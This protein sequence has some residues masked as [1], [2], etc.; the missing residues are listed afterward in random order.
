MA[1]GG[2]W[3]VSVHFSFA[4]TFINRVIEKK[5]EGKGTLSKD[6]DGFMCFRNRAGSVRVHPTGLSP[7][8]ATAW[9]GTLNKSSEVNHG[10]MSAKAHLQSEEFRF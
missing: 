2:T 8:S 4:V 7:S 9:S 6:P 3:R 1:S 5:G 10:C